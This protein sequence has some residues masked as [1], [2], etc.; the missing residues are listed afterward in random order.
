MSIPAYDT[1][2]ERQGLA[3]QRG[4]WDRYPQTYAREVDTR[5]APVIEAVIRRAALTPGVGPGALAD[6]TPFLAQLAEAGINAHVETETLG[7]DFDNFR[8]AWDVLASVTTAQLAPA[9]QQEAQAAVLATMWP[10]NDGPRHFR[11]VTQCIV[12]QR[13]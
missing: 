7:F 5:F 1:E 4:I 9:L 13:G 2:A 11:N 12:G 10:H 3:W 8:A 6:P